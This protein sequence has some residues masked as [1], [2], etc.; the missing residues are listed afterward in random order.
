MG[1]NKRDKFQVIPC[2]DIETAL[3]FWYIYKSR[4]VFIWSL[5]SLQSLKKWIK[6]NLAILTLEDFYLI[7]IA[8]IG[9]EV[10]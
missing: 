2:L 3:E 10:T 7:A 4:L 6:Y 9:K 5:R 1:R 8:T